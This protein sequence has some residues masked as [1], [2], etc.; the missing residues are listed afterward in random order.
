MTKDQ[1]V[2]LRELYKGN[3]EIFFDNAL[4]ADPN[5]DGSVFIWDDERELVHVIT[6][7]VRYTKAGS[8]QVVLSRTSAY[9]YIQ[10]ISCSM[11]KNESDDMMETLKS[12][13][14]VSKDTLDKYE[15]HFKELTA[16]EIVKNSGKNYL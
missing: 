16:E 10:A 8:K 15:N 2:Y 1:V 4:L 3:V 11:S 6:T 7:E 9:E 12:D 5:L 14:T 13:T